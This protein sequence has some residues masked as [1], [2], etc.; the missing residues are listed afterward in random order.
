MHESSN[1]A[2]KCIE[3]VTYLCISTGFHFNLK[4]EKTSSVFFLAGSVDVW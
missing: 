3:Q 4:D 2:S 1:A